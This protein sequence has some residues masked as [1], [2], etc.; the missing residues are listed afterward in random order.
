MGMS[1][2]VYEVL[3][4]WDRR[5]WYYGVVWNGRERYSVKF[6]WDAYKKEL[7]AAG[8]SLRNELFM[9]EEFEK[10]S[11]GEQQLVDLDEREMV[12]VTKESVNDAK[13][14]LKIKSGSNVSMTNRG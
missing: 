8:L 10:M 14:L 9:Q 12:D 2:R 3:E 5:D 11:N 13:T 1:V 7:V 6:P 4:S